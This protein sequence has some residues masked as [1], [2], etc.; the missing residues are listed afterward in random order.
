MRIGILT[1][2]GDV[3]PL[4]TVLAACAKACRHDDINLIGFLHGWEGVIEA[5]TTSLLEMDINPRIGGTLLKSSRLNP[6]KIR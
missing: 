4:N 2:G 1:G 5:R 3:P 6:R